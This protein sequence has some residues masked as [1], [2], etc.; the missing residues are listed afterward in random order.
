ML[1]IE[2]NVLKKLVSFVILLLTSII[3]GFAFVAQFFGADEVGPFAMNGLRFPL[4][5]LSIIPVMLIF[6]K[7]KS[8]KEERKKTK[9]ALRLILA[10]FSTKKSLIGLMNRDFSPLSP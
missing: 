1:Y 10:I 3:W 2:K 7:G 9:M 8:S 4:G 6:E 5:T